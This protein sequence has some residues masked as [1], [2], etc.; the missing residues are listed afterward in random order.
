MANRSSRKIVAATCL[1][2][3]VFA[4]AHAESETERS[5]GEMLYSTHCIACHTTH[6]HWRDQRLATD[7]ASLNRQV[8]RWQSN[9]SLNWNEEDIEA[10]SGYLN[11]LYYHFPAKARDKEISLK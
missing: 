1:F 3:G 4:E 6:V 5:R 8:R 11:A 10:V 7:W 9:T 2:V